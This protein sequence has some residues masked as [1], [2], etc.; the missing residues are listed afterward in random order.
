RPLPK[1]SHQ[2][3]SRKLQ[4]PDNFHSLTAH[5][6]IKC[7][8]G[9]TTNQCAII[10]KPIDFIEALEEAASKYMT[11]LRILFRTGITASLTTE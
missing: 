10:W 9:H 5:Q 1:H 8:G 2:L 6:Q 11:P 4:S 7:G 3:L